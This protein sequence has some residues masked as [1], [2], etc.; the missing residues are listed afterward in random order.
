MPLQRCTSHAETRLSGTATSALDCY[1][2]HMPGC[3]LSIPVPILCAQNIH[4]CILL[5]QNYENSAGG[6][7]Q[8]T[9]V[10]LRWRCWETRSCFREG[11]DDRHLK[12]C[13]ARIHEYGSPSRRRIKRFLILMAFTGVSAAV[14]AA[15]VGIISRYQPVSKSRLLHRL[16][17]PLSL[18]T[19]SYLEL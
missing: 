5:N 15:M 8:T 14:P 4:H 16:L 9:K 17:E 11:D 12:A 2:P 1:L 19:I 7:R 10:N 18:H 6:S 13:K 3:R